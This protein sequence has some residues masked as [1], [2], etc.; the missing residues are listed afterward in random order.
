MR[1]LAGAHG[2]LRAFR[3]HPL[4]LCRRFRRF[5][6]WP[7][8]LDGRERARRGQPAGPLCRACGPAPIAARRRCVTHSPRPCATPGPL[9][10]ADPQA[11]PAGCTPSM[12]GAPPSP[13]RQS[14]PRSR[15]PARMP[16]GRDRDEQLPAAI[17]I[18]L[19]GRE[20]AGAHRR[21]DQG[22]VEPVAPRSADGAQ[23]LGLGLAETDLDRHRGSSLPRPRD[24]RRLCHTTA[25]LLGRSADRAGS[26][27]LRHRTAS[28]AGAHEGETRRARGLGCDNSCSLPCFAL[29]LDASNR[30]ASR[31]PFQPGAHACRDTPPSATGTR[32]LLH[33][34]PR[35]ST[36]TPAVPP[37]QA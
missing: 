32:P 9:Q 18:R 14:C 21:C 3:A 31:F 7:A 24:V 37:T 8:L 23:G 26:G 35:R 33:E 19:T 34:P 4:P 16:A 36:A 27:E 12:R 13:V 30:P 6:Q 28:R 20:P 29:H 25:G 11:S 5:R 10:T 22:I 17:F 2:V 15:R 1:Q